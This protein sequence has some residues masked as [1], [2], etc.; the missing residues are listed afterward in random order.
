MIFETWEKNMLSYYMI[1]W[2]WFLFL[3][4]YTEIHVNVNFCI[5][6]CHYVSMITSS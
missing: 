1:I 4:S 3:K 2:S 5:I 6:E